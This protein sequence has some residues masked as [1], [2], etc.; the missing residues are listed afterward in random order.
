VNVDVSRAC[1]STRQL[2]LRE[3]HCSDR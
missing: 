2:N 1:R 3:I